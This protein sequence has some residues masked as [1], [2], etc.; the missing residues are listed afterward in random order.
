MGSNATAGK[1]DVAVTVKS[2]WRFSYRT[3]F[4]AKIEYQKGSTGS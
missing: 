3:D 2:A 4:A 1:F